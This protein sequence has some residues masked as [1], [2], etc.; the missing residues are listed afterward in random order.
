MYGNG[1]HPR[2]VKDPTSEILKRGLS[3]VAGRDPQRDEV[4]EGSGVVGRRVVLSWRNKC[5]CR[6]VRR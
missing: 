4:R 3:R 6:T 5:L 1:R 2:E